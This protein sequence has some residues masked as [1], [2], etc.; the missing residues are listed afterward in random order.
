MLG[1][2]AEEGRSG[3]CPGFRKAHQGPHTKANQWQGA[4]V[5][6]GALRHLPRSAKEV[7]LPDH[8]AP[9]TKERLDPLGGAV[10]PGDRGNIKRKLGGGVEEPLEGGFGLG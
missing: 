2:P 9:L 5:L 1:E 8:P 10:L 3:L 7:A 4:Q 6:C